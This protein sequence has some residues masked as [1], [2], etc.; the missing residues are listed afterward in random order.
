[1]KRISTIVFV[2]FPFFSLFCT[3]L[4]ISFT[5]R[6]G[7]PVFKYVVV[8]DLTEV[9]ELA[10]AD[11]SATNEFVVEVPDNTDVFVLGVASS[12][13]SNSGYT[14]HEFMPVS[15]AFKIGRAHV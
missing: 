9:S 14:A 6:S 7:N 5:S 4:N 1:M 10:S 11:M 15:K 8:Y 2:V 3:T 12:G 13:E